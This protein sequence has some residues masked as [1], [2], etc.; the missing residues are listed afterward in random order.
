MKTLEWRN[1]TLIIL[2]QVALPFH[3]EYRHASHMSDVVEAIRRLE[4]RGAPAI[5]IAAAFGYVLGIREYGDHNDFRNRND[6]GNHNDCGDHNNCGNHNDCGNHIPGSFSEHT[7]T[8]FRTLASS[9]PTAVNLFWA[10]ERMESILKTVQ[11]TIPDTITP[12]AL[13]ALVRELTQEAQLIQHED[14]G[15]NRLIGQHGHQ[16]IPDNANILTH[17]NTGSLAASEFGTALGVIR[18]AHETGK[19]LHVYVDE[20]RPLLQGARLTT[21]ELLRENIPFTLITDSMAGYLMSQN[22]I[23]LIITGADR[24]AANGDTANKIGTYSL[25]VLAKAHNIPFYIAAPQSTIDRKIADGTSIIIEE[26]DPE[27]IRCFGSQ[28]ITLPEVPVYNPAFDITPAQYISGIITEKG[29]LEPCELLS[30]TPQ[31]PPDKH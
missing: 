31:T 18:T 14:T 8:V 27:E 28:A 19:Q 24:I 17:C 29:I 10:L 13:A 22:K 21:W 26:R 4:V 11:K 7:R 25:A 30:K 3:V 2:N 1:D 5:G 12:D 20:T 23:D 16:I 15:I 9:R 6:C